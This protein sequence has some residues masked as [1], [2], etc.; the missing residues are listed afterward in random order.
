MQCLRLYILTTYLPKVG[1]GMVIMQ[2]R[3]LNYLLRHRVNIAQDITN[4]IEIEYERLYKCF[5]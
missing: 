4:M 3:R 1:M 2:Y 5:V